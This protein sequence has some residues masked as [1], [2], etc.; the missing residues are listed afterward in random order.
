MNWI[1]YNPCDPVASVDRALMHIQFTTQNEKSVSK[2]QAIIPNKNQLNMQYCMTVT[3]AYEEVILSTAS[4]ISL[5]TVRF[6]TFS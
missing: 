5:R 2:L 4:F 6:S 1:Y 3:Y